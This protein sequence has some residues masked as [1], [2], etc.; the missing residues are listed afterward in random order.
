LLLVGSRRMGKT[1]ILYQL[2]R[3]LGPDFA[4]AIVDC[5]NYAVKESLAA[6]FTHLSQRIAEALRH[7]HVSVE[8]LLRSALKEE[9]FALF[10]EWLQGVE[11]ALPPRMRVL[12]CLDEYER[13]QTILDAGWGS[14][15]FDYLRHL[16]QHRDRLVLMFT[17]A[18]SF[19]ELGAAWIDRFISVRRLRVG[20]LGR[21]DLTSL[22][23]RPIP[24]FD[25]SYAPGALEALLDAANGQPMLTQAVAFELVCYLN[26]QQRRT[27]TRDDVE[28]A[29]NRAVDSAP[30][31]FDYLWSDVGEQGQKLLLAI[32]KRGKLVGGDEATFQRLRDRDVLNEAGRFAVPMVERWLRKY[33][34]VVAS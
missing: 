25:M 2:P 34:G 4:P 31:Y 17:G 3:M 23:T 20:F 27:A 21:D 8:P 6:L 12:L 15:L 11:A 26:Q 33:K 24:E 29:I 9:P 1:S 19:E 32:L 22:L 13:L 30:G 5:Q 28:L 7:R 10:D 16:L 18:L 14:Q